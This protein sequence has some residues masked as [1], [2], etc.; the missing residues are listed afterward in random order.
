MSEIKISRAELFMMLED[1]RSMALFLSESVSL[2]LEACSGY[3]EDLPVP[4][5]AGRCLD[6]LA[7]KINDISKSI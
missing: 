1:C 4:H 7:S 6:A 2:I 3:P 5:G